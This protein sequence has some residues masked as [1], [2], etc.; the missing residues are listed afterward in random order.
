MVLEQVPELLTLLGRHQLEDWSAAFLVEL[1][2]EIGGV[3]RRHMREQLRGLTVGARLQEFHLVLRLQFLE[4]I[5]GQLRISF[6]CVD[7]LLA[8]LVQQ[9]LTGSTLEASNVQPLCFQL[10]ATGLDAYHHV[11]GHEEVA[12]A[13]PDLPAAHPRVATIRQ[14]CDH[15]FDASN[16]IASRTDDRTMNEL[17]QQQRRFSRYVHGSISAPRGA[18]LGSQK[19]TGMCVGGGG[20]L[21]NATRRG[22]C[23]ER[24]HQTNH[25]S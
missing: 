15:V 14:T 25:G 10:Y 13:D 22:M 8:M 21:A 12:T 5:G 18:S 11:L 9:H 16:T 19:P 1:V 6:Y 4:H 17:R 23:T 20:S 24:I 7:N 2:Q 3:I